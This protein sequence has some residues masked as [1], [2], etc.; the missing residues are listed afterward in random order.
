[1]KYTI[2]KL[3]FASLASFILTF[4]AV[5]QEEVKGLKQLFDITIDELGNATVAVSMKLNASQ[6][7]AFKRNVGNNTSNLKRGM[8]DALPKYFLTNFNYS[9]E[10]MNRTYTM[11]F[12]VKGLV[13][14]DKNG[15][16]T[17]EL[18]TKDPD[19]TKLGDREFV[20]TQDLSSD[21]ML[22]QQTQKIHLPSRASSAKIEKDS[23]GK[24]IL[25]Y[26]IGTPLKHTIITV[27]GIILIL[28]GGF[29]FYKNQSTRQNN[30]KVAK[31]PVAA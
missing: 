2:S 8:E 16:W 18:D 4:S 19:V 27:L 17:A 10:Q 6:W 9:E 20:I 14:N 11:K 5:A 12:D 29:F 26:T 23:F 31:E 24:A 30:L 13:K 7:D 28:G 1:M 3:F 21:G 25:T 22:L 15:K